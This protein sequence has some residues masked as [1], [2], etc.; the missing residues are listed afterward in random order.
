MGLLISASGLASGLCSRWL[1]NTRYISL[2]CRPIAA[3]A[4]VERR[5]TSSDDRNGH[6]HP[7][8][9]HP[10]ARPFTETFTHTSSA[11]VKNNTSHM[12]TLAAFS[13][14][15]GETRTALKDTVLS[16]HIPGAR[17]QPA[18]AEPVQ[19]RHLNVTWLAR[20]P[21]RAHIQHT[22]NHLVWLNH[23]AWQSF[24]TPRSYFTTHYHVHFHTSE[25]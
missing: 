22:Y 13:C 1:N 5:G 8:A 18:G 3:G 21:W 17:A 14:S 23:L 24:T 15:R 11:Q 20:G 19:P 25:G 6:L 2:G 12:F 7:L 4:R 16:R 10:L 9:L